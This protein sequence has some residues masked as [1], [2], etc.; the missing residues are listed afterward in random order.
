MRNLFLS[1]SAVNILVAFMEKQITSLIVLT[2]TAPQE[3]VRQ[4][5]S[6]FFQIQLTCKTEVL[7]LLWVSHT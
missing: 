2:G 1:Y 3:P 4:L 6:N 5:A 7:I